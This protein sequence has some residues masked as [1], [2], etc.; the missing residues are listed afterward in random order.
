MTVIAMTREI[1]SRG[2]DVAAEW[3]LNW[4]LRSSILK[5][6]CRICRKLG[7]GAGRRPALLGREGVFVRAMASR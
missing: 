2:T 3:P 5:L 4:D 7:R 6:L 1:G